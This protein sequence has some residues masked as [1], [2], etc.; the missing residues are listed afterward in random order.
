MIDK[1]PAMD[2]ARAAYLTKAITAIASSL[3]GQMLDDLAQPSTESPSISDQL[4]T[5]AIRP[6]IPK[7]RDSLLSKLSEADP[8]TVERMMG[9]TATAIESL[10]AQAP[11]APLARYRMEWDMADGHLVLMP[12]GEAA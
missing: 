11:G 2:P 12:L 4:L 8:I 5:R 10:L 3:I 6:W 1:P 9:A 7:L